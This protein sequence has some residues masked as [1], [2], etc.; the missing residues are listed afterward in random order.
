MNQKGMLCITLIIYKNTEI[1]SSFEY[2]PKGIIP[3]TLFVIKTLI[4]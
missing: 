3:I 1:T 4:D 2:I